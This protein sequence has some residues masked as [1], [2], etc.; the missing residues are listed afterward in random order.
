MAAEPE[1]GPPDAPTWWQL[2]KPVVTFIG[3]FALIFFLLYSLTWNRFVEDNVFQ[4][5]LA[6][7]TTVSAKL[8][9]L[10]GTEIDV[11]GDTI[12]AGPDW[13]IEVR[14]GCDAVEPSALYIAAVVAF[15]AAI[16]A[17]LV[18]VIVG[19]GFLALVNLGRIVSLFYIR[20]HWPDL[21]D[22]MHLEIWQ[23]AFI[24][25]A[26]VTFLLWA[27]RASRPAPASDEG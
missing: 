23:V 9:G 21:F 27:R 13:S 3:T 25:L 14:R 22:M 1:D 17:K 26:L 20:R 4:P 24:V 16:G 11:W 18:G 2:N 19:V 7:N 6:L 8:I 15:P 12:L 10:L 5:Y